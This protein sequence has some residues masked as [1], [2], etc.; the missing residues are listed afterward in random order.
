[1]ISIERHR[2]VA[3]LVIALTMLLMAS[4]MSVQKATAADARESKA[5]ADE[6]KRYDWYGELDLG[7][8]LAPKSDVDYASGGTGTFDTAPGLLTR[9]AFGRRLPF[10]LRAEASFAYRLLKHAATRIPGVECGATTAVCD[11]NGAFRLFN[12][13]HLMTFMGNVYYDILNPDAALQIY[14]GGG[15]GGGLAIVKE[16]AAQAIS[17]DDQDLTLAWNVAAG[18][19]FPVIDHVESVIGYRYSRTLDF[20]FESSRGDIEMLY[21]VHDVV[22]GLQYAF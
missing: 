15:L 16:S 19:R 9:A 6:V 18:F 21:Q 7:I 22:V 4:S 12:E 2:R 5:D 1:M 8:S 14:V 20:E 11:G 17:I 13:T 10:G 3:S